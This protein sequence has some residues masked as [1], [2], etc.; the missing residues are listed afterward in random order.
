M[1]GAKR[2]DPA[3]RLAGLTDPQAAAMRRH[4]GGRGWLR[5]VVPGAPLLWLGAF[6]LLPCLVVVRMSFSEAVVAQPP[7]SPLW[8]WADGALTL[9][10]HLDT[11]G[12]LFGDWL[13]A[14]ALLGSVW[15]AGV[16][17]AACL[18][19]GYPIALAI[20]RTAP[21][22][23][24]P[25]LMAVMLPFWTSFLIRVYAWILILKDEGL[26]N[27]ALAALGLGRLHVMNTDLA[28]CIGITYS[29]LP[30]MVLPLYATLVAQDP[31]LREAAAD[32]RASP[33]RVFRTVTLPLSLP[34]V[35][36]GTLLVFIPAC[37]EFVIPDLLGG[38]DTLMIGRVLWGE[39]FSNHDW[40]VASA[41]AV[42]LL[43]VLALPAALLQRGRAGG[44][45]AG[46]VVGGEA[47]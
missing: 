34:G 11:Y 23:R 36:A 37:G 7:V 46:D 21:S 9:T 10:L 20:A 33:W 24:G 18:L 42:A 2:T 16:S 27:Q 35:L 47:E 28:V 43:A 8:H 19:L 1:S 41:V 5:A 29:Y 39:F 30:F 17:T 13:Y 26:L 32:L 12:T 14:R 45:A 25:L 15:I 31:A 3:T 44:L 6:F 4:Q 22:R 40:P 38:P